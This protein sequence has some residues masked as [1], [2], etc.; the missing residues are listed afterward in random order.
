MFYLLT[1]LD[2]KLL[3]D[4]WRIKGQGIAI[5]LVIA[6][7]IGLFIM[8]N[9]MLSSLQETRQAYYDRY[10]FADIFAPIKRAPDR[11]LAEIKT[12]PGV[13]A[14]E[15]RIS[16]GVLIDAPGT[17]EPITGQAVS[18]PRLGQPVLNDIFLRK[19]R[20]L[21]PTREDEILLSEP[22]ANAHG[23]EPGDTISATMNGSKREFEIVGIALSPEF[24]Y[25][26]APGALVPDPFRF[27]ILWIGKDALAAAFDLDGAF[28][29]VLISRSHNASESDIIASLDRLLERYGATG[30]FL[31]ADQ[32]SDKFLESE[33]DQL[34]TMAT[35]LPSI[36]LAVSAFLLNVVIARIVDSEREQIGLLKSFGYSNSAILF[37][38]LKMVLVITLLGVFVGFG[39]GMW[40]G[41]WMALLYQEFYKFPFLIFS[42]GLD[43]LAWAFTIAVSVAVL[44]TLTAVRRAAILSPAEAMRPP[45]PANYR[46]AGVMPLWFSER[47]DQPT[48]MILRRIA[49]QPVRALLTSVGLA[50]ATAILIT[51]R[52]N[53]DSVTY[54]MD[55]NFNVAERQDLTVTFV[56]PESDKAI[57]ELRRMDGVLYAEPFRSVAVRLRNGHIE[58]RQSLTGLVERPLLSRA[59]NA[60]L[61]S[62][63][64]PQGGVLLSKALADLI[65]ADIGDVLQ[66]DV[67]EDRKPRLDLTVTGVAETFIG[68]SAYLEIGS[69]NRSLKE[70]ARVSGAFLMIDTA[71]QDAIYERLKDMPSVS[72]VGI[73]AAAQ[74]S[75]HDTMDQGIGTFIAI[76]STFAGLIAVGVVY[77]S[78]RIAL[79]E[80]SRELASLRVLGF[81]KN[82]AS[83]ILL[84]EIALLTLLA[85][86][87]GCGFGYLLAW[88]LSESFTT[89][90]YQIPLVIELAS[91]GYACAVVAAASLISGILVDRE[92]GRLDL[93]VALKTRE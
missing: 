15:G 5:A 38:Y 76:I 6:C 19:G 87:I 4:L 52:F 91:Y 34:A 43:T 67:L 27:G 75:F 62:L 55:V 14:V 36:F 37:Q 26:I 22:F 85:L 90:L 61:A 65:Q 10:R 40:L 77:N 89:E 33:L 73:L 71:K 59:V 23:F 66:V 13:R 18:L 51:A 92:I 45:A 63:Q 41:R 83:Y 64:M 84:G 31:R 48:R 79:A 1:S 82:E 53:W 74:R 29:E 93:V 70:G 80:R 21:D 56:E 39:V 3:R 49:R 68:T 88:F 11:V 32:I 25:A 12:F 17:T 2:R 30:A 35:V 46:Q 78:A 60:D 44:G 69:L 72:G 50:F 7:G 28:N 47:I 16:A 81:T 9:G 57:Y 86:P 8:A 42:L 24:T 58:R 20:M 54:M